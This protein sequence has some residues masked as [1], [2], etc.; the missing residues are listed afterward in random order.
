[1]TSSL[2]LA[3]QIRGTGFSCRRCGSCCRETEPGSNLVMVG[4]EEITRIMKAT[5]LSFE[6]IAEPYPDRICEGDRDY[7]FGWV[8]RRIG[9]R[10]RFLDGSTCQIYETRPWICRTYPFMLDENGLSVYPCEGIDQDFQT[11]DA[12]IIAFDLCRRYAYEREQDEKIRMII[13]SETIPA[14]RPVVIDAEGIKEYHG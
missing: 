3:E 7:T 12:V 5:G 6:E 2:S 10:C 14:G 8:L 1:M 13:Q 9:D 4:Q 11:P